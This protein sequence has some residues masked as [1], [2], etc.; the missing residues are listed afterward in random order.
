MKLKRERSSNKSVEPPD[1][2][3]GLQAT[4]QISE[5]SQKN[6]GPSLPKVPAASSS[7]KE[8]FYIL[9]CKG[10]I[11]EMRCSFLFIYAPT[12]YSTFFLLH[13]PAPA[14]IK[15]DFGAMRCKC[16]LAVW[17]GLIWV[18]LDQPKCQF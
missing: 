10:V 17:A 4:H 7:A 9:W 13:A 12:L 3:G 6:K 1:S 14:L 8:T 11:G 15:I 5:V 16:G 2:Q 18:R